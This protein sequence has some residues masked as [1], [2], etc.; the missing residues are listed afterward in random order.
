ML[1][2]EVTSSLH[3]AL[4]QKV[5]QSLKTLKD[6]TIIIVTHRKEV[7]DICDRVIDFDEVSV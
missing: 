3:P 2:D 5:I 7:L 4:E 6:K 1:L